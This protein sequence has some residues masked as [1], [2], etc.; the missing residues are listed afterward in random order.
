M[1]NNFPPEIEKRLARISIDGLE[2]KHA[3]LA[4][5][6]VGGL[7]AEH[8]AIFEE[9]GTLYSLA[10]IAG[11][12]GGKGGRKDRAVAKK[13]VR[14][15][16]M[17]AD[18]A[19]KPG[20]AG[21]SNKP[22]AGALKKPGV[23]VSIKKGS[24]LSSE[25]P[26]LPKWASAISRAEEK[27]GQFKEKM[28]TEKNAAKKGA[29]KLVFGLNELSISMYKE[30][31]NRQGDQKM[32]L[33]YAKRL[34]EEQA[35]RSSKENIER[36]MQGRDGGAKAA[37][38]KYDLLAPGIDTSKLDGLL[39]QG[40]K[41][42]NVTGHNCREFVEAYAVLREHFPP[43]ELDKPTD[44]MGMMDAGPSFGKAYQR[45][46][47]VTARDPGGR[48]V[49]AHDGNYFGSESSSALYG[50][51]I[52]V[53]YE[54]RK[55]GVATLILAAALTVGNQCAADAEK[56]WAARGKLIDYEKMI[57]GG[58]EKGDKRIIGNR[59]MYGIGEVEP[60]NLASMEDAQATIERNLIHGRMFAFSVIPMVD[61][62]QVDLDWEAGKPYAESNGKPPADWNTVP[63]LLYVRRVGKESAKAIS[64]GEAKRISRIMTD[65]FS[66]AGMYSPEGVEADYQHSI[67]RMAGM[68]DTDKIPI[69]ALPRDPAKS[70]RELLEELFKAIPQ[71]GTMHERCAQF[72]PD[73]AWAKEYLSEYKKAQKKGAAVTLEQAKEHL[74]AEATRD[75]AIT[76]TRD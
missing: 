1:A 25:G 4:S 27:N 5:D 72:Y 53:F 35:Y 36:I 29:M 47:L 59:L 58:M 62:K 55:L 20:E 9:D 68:K 26:M 61:Y 3:E 71:I 69:V 28:E 65:I 46:Y 75:P 17:C 42:S 44:L 31:A 48:I 49:G 8:A 12:I 18:I 76:V 16:A 2:G 21:K 74:L 14:L 60:V 57:I 66:E 51:H 63:L 22:S 40:Y 33:A 64:V 54:E 7:S 6:V 43:D 11:M 38:G 70:K 37:V 39:A 34:V 15:I 50:A 23:S 73:Y 10:R 19:Q 45:Y 56:E 32:A 41:I 13:I 52:G 67:A 24:L 30:W